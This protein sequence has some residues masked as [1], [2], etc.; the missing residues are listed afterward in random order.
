MIYDCKLFFRWI[1]DL[2]PV[3]RTSR[4]FSGEINP[5]IS[6][7]RTSFK[8]WNLAVILPF[9]VSETYLKS[10][11]LRQADHSF[12]NCFS[13]PI[14]YRVFRETAPWPFRQ[15]MM[16][17]VD[18]FISAVSQC[19]FRQHRCVLNSFIR[20][21]NGKISECCRSVRRKRNNFIFEDLSVIQQFRRIVF[22]E[23]DRAKSLMLFSVWECFCGCT[24]NKL[25]KERWEIK[26]QCIIEK[27]LLRTRLVSKR[28]SCV[29]VW[30][31]ALFYALLFRSS[32]ENLHCYL[33]NTRHVSWI[34]LNPVTTRIFFY[35]D[36]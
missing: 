9:L 26:I 23:I 35:K 21:T 29:L 30:K 12:N 11:F 17:G 10:S 4:N 13:G 19:K 14:S 1:P 8:L 24:S 34:N 2:G 7:I 20:I 36:H 16:C 33:T 27:T 3:S 22:S 18:F 15:Q 28:Q 32:E 31:K 5:F 25:I 6:S